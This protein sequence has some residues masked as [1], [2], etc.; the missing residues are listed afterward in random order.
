MTVRWQGYVA[1]C[2]QVNVNSL[3]GLLLFSHDD[4]IDKLHRGSVV[5]LRGFGK[6]GALQ[7]YYFTQALRFVVALKEGGDS[8]KLTSHRMVR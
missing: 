3:L 5:V 2:C 4:A 6:F 1:R 8:H 7:S